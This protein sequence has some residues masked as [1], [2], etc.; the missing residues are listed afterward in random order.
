MRKNIFKIAFGVAI[1]ILSLSVVIYGVGLIYPEPNYEDYCSNSIVRPILE[2]ESSCFDNG[3]KWNSYEVSKGDITGYC[4]IDY[5]CGEAYNLARERYSM[6]LFLFFVP[7]GILIL[8]AGV[9]IRV[10]SVSYGVLFSGI[11]L[12]LK[13]L[14][15][16][17]RYSENWLRF[18]ISLIGLGVVVYFANKFS[19][20]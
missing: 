2:N 12:I 17:W 3:G 6:N 13:G 10:E 4:D 5:R 15:G 8:I 19:E 11:A 7:F 18:L 14:F 9:Y 16:Y 20:K 1:F